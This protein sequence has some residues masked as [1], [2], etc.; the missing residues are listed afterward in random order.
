MFCFVFLSVGS[1]DH[2]TC[3]CKI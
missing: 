3:N 1:I 2:S